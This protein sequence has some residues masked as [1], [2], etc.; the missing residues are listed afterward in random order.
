MG[1][2]GDK[3]LKVPVSHIQ[4]DALSEDASVLSP[5]VTGERLR[6]RR[7]YISRQIRSSIFCLPPSPWLL[8]HARHYF[9]CMH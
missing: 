2:E 1:D 9:V 5:E 8:P 3:R 6:G 4:I 7:P